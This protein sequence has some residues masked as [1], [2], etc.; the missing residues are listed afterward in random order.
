M[1]IH[2]LAAGSGY[3]YLTR[4]VAR[5]DATETGHV[6]LA[7]YYT[8]RGE[9]PGVWVGSGM[10]GIVGLQVGDEVTAE[11]MARLFGTGEHPLGEAVGGSLGAAFRVYTGREDVSP[12]RVQVA[13]GLEQY[14]RSQGLPAN[15]PI[16][17]QERARIRTEVASEMFGKEHQRAPLS[18]RELAGFIAVHS[19]SKT[20]AVAGFDLTFSPVKS[21]STLW[22][23]AD[24][25]TAAQIEAAHQRAVGDALAF[26]E[27][28]AL[29]TRT[30]RNGVQQVDVRGLVATAFTHRDSRAGDPDLHTHVAVANKVQTLDG[31]WLSIDGRLLFKAAVTASETYNTALEKHL[32]PL[33][34]AFEERRGTDPQKRPVREV[35]GVDP[36]LN[37]RWSSRR[38]S[39]EARRGV[40]AR[41]FQGRHG[42]PPTPVESIQLAQQA[43]LETREAKH[44]PRSLAL[45]RATWH[46]EAAHVL[47]GEQAVQAMVHNARSGA[48][49]NERG[50]PVT[51]DWVQETA[52][53]IVGTLESSRSTWQ[54]WHV[55]AEAQRR[56][57][58]MDLPAETVEA[59]VDRLSKE[60]LRL[61]Q[62]LAVRKDPVVEPSPLRRVDG[63]SVYHVA[64]SDLFTSTTVMDAEHRLVATAGRLDGRRAAP[65]AVEVALLES[66]ANG[67]TLNAGQAA[68]VREMATSGARL[69]LAIAPAGAGKTTA[70][71]SL[72]RAWQESG[73]T[74]LGLAPS[75]A[76]A[77]V[78]RDQAGTHTDTL[79][80][81]VW[82]LAHDPTNLPPWAEDTGPDSLVL[83]DEAGMADTLSLDKAVAFITGRGASV[84]LIGDDQQ[85]AAIR[86]GGV[87]RD[88]RA[89]HGALHLS[90]LMRFTGAA[91][92]GAS[93]ALRDGKPEALGFYLDAGRVHVGDIATM[94]EAVFSSWQADRAR[95]R[96]AIMLAPTR[97]LVAELNQR[98]RAHRLEGID[99]PGPVLTLADGNEA[100]VG[101]LVITR[102]ND[103]RLRMTATDWVKN[104]DRWT[105]LDLPGDGSLQVQH[106]RTHRVIALPAGYVHNCTELGY[107]TTVHR[108]QGVSVDV[109]HALATGAES[110]Q[111]LYTMMT[112]GA[113][114]N[115]LYLQVVGDGDEHNLIKPGTVH[116]QTATDLLEAVLSRD[117]SPV[118][119]T[120][121]G[122]TLSD[123]AH[124][125]GQACDRYLDALYTAATDRLG[126][127]QLARLEEVADLLVPGLTQAP[128][129]PTLRAHLTLL[130][131][132][133]TDPA[134]ALGAAVASREL[135]TASDP[136]AVLGWRLDDSGLRNAG[137]GPLPWVPGV[138]H[139]LTEHPTW[140][141]YLT[142]RAA[143]VVSLARE[144][145][146]QAVGSLVPDWAAQGGTTRPGDDLLAK[147]AVWRAA[148]HAG[149]TDLRP[150]GP[151]Q[152]DK[153]PALHQRALREQLAGGR[154]PALAEWGDLIARLS[155]QARSDDFAPV[156][157]ERLAAVS[158][159]GLDAA[160]LVSSAAQT[161]P[162]PDDHAAAALWWRIAEHLSPAVTA[163]A[164]E[165][166]TVTAGWVPT[167]ADNLG[168]PRVQAMQD[169]PWWP[170]L[171]TSID[172]ALQRGWTIPQ[173]ASTAPQDGA[174]ID[175]DLADQ[176][177]DRPATG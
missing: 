155:Q 30:G 75:A 69:Q 35:V 140:G 34:L 147:V 87:L 88:I 138:P 176:R 153:A 59:L 72:T 64:G 127:D 80:K 25:S 36:R 161:G 50:D 149:P 73:G 21:V 122:R 125:L 116:P 174:D 117:E 70:M 90:E 108:A 106:T 38:A 146:T 109:S 79:A 22:A 143:L 49:S 55:R 45:Q 10:A 31:K 89:T 170:A 171:V 24:L 156:L 119:A 144:V 56:V 104:G 99:T 12:F 139:T 44:E 97:E 92:G 157:A 123:S 114:A 71:R 7:S 91:E 131:A 126:P 101:D 58:R 93:L 14:N 113:H 133:G 173:L 135:D 137:P 48:I 18:E 15:H 9:S 1:S 118:S 129:W 102:T 74:V 85:L 177:P 172:H 175:D 27:G 169:S 2:K 42:R 39:I 41:E 78:L 82:T 67:V 66:V 53:R 124:L 163:Q 81:L 165:P 11:Q 121:M 134:M 95:G 46:A 33:G 19:R 166:H 13:R 6:G 160:G 43:T 130:A 63:S 112:R 51:Q 167:L 86:A 3:D 145:A 105:I 142:R 60:A 52:R 62:G 68:L 94:T 148:T 100:S 40:L 164:D 128:A 16:A 162:L 158:R 154:A 115:H 37:Q 61:S 57:R 159:A 151:P 141:D 110:R 76:A 20:T 168:T 98:A 96:D 107:A 32:R 132:N 65:E 136:A 77:A 83:V 26:L 29:F 28:H 17:V 111:Q 84:R 54:V 152:V 23:V 47:G 4:Q 8:A 150:T 120:T 5:Q 103:R